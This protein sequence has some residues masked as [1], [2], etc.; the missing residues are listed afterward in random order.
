M[1]QGLRRRAGG[2]VEA[3]VGD[4]RAT[5]PELA[6]PAE[7]LLVEATV[8]PLLPPS[9][10][11]ATAV[12]DLVVAALGAVGRGARPHRHGI[13]GADAIAVWIGCTIAVS[14]DAIV[15]VYANTADRDQ[16]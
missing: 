8:V 6:V 12:T 15:V 1:L 14:A 16:R 3:S 7:A 13:R 4:G 9:E 2:F 10:G 5:R 11:A